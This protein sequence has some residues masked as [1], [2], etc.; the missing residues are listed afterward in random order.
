MPNTS[1]K[2]HRLQ[3]HLTLRK[4]TFA[5]GSN[6]KIVTDLPMSVTVEKLGPPDF[7][8]CSVEIYGL[9]LH[10]L[11]QLTSLAF[12]ILQFSRNYINIYAG[13]DDSGLSEIF[14][15][16]IISSHADFSG[17]PDIKLVIDGEVGFWGRVIAQGPN[18]INGTQDA[19]AFIKRQVEQ[20]EFTFTNEGVSATLKNCV[21]NGDPIAQ[22]RAAAVQIGADLIFDDNEAI[23]LPKNGHRGGDVLEIDATSGLLGYPSVSSNGVEFKSIFHP[24][25]RFAGLINLK[26]AVP[27]CSNTWRIIKLT[28]KLSANNAND[29]SWE[30]QITGYY[31][32]LSGEIGKFV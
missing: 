24:S 28:H 27:K 8:K 17:A 18:V 1:F 25:F 5:D 14:A 11:E 15:G 29:S 2:P 30:S 10:E 12:N 3:V 26:T 20:A 4:G 16:T 32:E 23:L 6:S 31:P 22:A 19:A 21:F 13:D 7:A 9:P